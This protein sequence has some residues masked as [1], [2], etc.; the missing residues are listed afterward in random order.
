MARQPRRTARKVESSQLANSFA[1]VLRVDNVSP[2]FSRLGAGQ[3]PDTIFLNDFFSGA[4]HADL[5][6]ITPARRA[7]DAF[8]RQ[9]IGTD[10]LNRALVVQSDRLWLR[11]FRIRRWKI[12][13]SGP[14]ILFLKFR[15]KLLD[16]FTVAHCGK[17]II[18]CDTVF[19]LLHARDLKH[20][21]AV[22]RFTNR[23]SSDENQWADF[24][25]C[26]QRAYKTLYRKLVVEIRAQL[27][28]LT[29]I[30]AGVGSELLQTESRK[31]NF[32][33]HVRGTVV[34]KSRAFGR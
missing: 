11:Q 4:V 15:A 31:I 24:D 34:A 30:K 8:N 33:G 6:R 18:P 22:R 29:V 27:L 20:D 3:K 16:G 9:P 10:D 12:D 26:F 19:H 28:L 32:Q 13:C 5:E 17:E 23:N 25:C 14:L 21:P 7:I 1:E 2:D